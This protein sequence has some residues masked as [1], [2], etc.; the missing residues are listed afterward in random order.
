MEISDALAALIGLAALTGFVHTLAGPDHYVPFVMMSRARGW[1]WTQTALVT[2]LCGVG[3]VLGSVVLGGIGIAAG[4]AISN[5]EAVESSRGTVAAWLMIG[6]GLLYAAWGFRRFMIGRKHTHI[7]VHD[8]AVI[9]RHMHGHNPHGH[10]N[11]AHEGEARPRSVTPWVLFTIFVFGPCEV[12]IP[13]LMIPAANESLPGLILVTAVFGLTT[14]STM[15][16]MVLALSFGF[17]MMHL[18]W[19]ERHIHTLSG[20][21]IALCGALILLGL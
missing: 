5:I 18:G 16:V 17:R 10:H 3:H 20:A 8:E 12:L 4:L 11:H 2:F 7:H 6:F 21:A 13:I 1:S 19:V 9:H 15:L 14:I